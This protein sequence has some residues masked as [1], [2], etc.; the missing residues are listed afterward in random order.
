MSALSFFTNVGV[1]K[2]GNIG[3]SLISWYAQA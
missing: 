3:D 2:L 1:A